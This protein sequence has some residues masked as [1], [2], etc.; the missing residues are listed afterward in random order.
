MAAMTRDEVLAVVAKARKEGVRANLGYTNLRGADLGYADL[1]YADLGGANLGYTTGAG[2]VCLSVQGLPSGIAT[3]GGIGSSPQ[4]RALHRS[5]S[6]PTP[7]AHRAR[8]SGA[9]RS[10][11][12]PD[13]AMG[14]GTGG[15]TGGSPGGLC[16]D[17]LPPQPALALP[18]AH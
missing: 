17:L 8:Q 5:Y 6:T 9:T 1:G 10:G 3:P 2:Q 16:P 13:M 7:L 14:L 18:G 15:L 11:D 12:R 4:P